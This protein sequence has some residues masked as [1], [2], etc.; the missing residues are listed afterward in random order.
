MLGGERHQIVQHRFGL[1]LR[2]IMTS[3][4][5]AAICLSV[6]VTWGA[7][8]TDAAAFFAGAAAFFGGAA[9]FA[10]AA[11]LAD[12]AAAFLAVE[13]TFFTGGMTIS[14]LNSL[15]QHAYALCFGQPQ[16]RVHCS[17]SP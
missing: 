9:F 6:M 7:T 12:G 4:N 15:G 5:S 10:A 2:Q 16:Q 13:A 17:I 8:F 3:A 1:F 14:L 11:T